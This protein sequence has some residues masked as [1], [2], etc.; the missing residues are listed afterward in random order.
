MKRSIAAQSD[1]ALTEFAGSPKGP[2]CELYGERPPAAVH[3]DDRERMLLMLRNPVLNIHLA[4]DLVVRVMR[5]ADEEIPLFSQD[6]RATRI[7]IV[8]RSRIQGAKRASKNKGT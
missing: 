6:Q 3:Q 5:A 8:G 1:W 2:S 7:A 4:D